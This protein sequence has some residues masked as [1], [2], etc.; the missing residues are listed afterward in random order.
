MPTQEALQATRESLERM[1]QFDV[2]TLAR[3]ED[4]GKALSFENALPAAEKLVQLY[5]RLGLSVLEDLTDQHLGTVKTQADADYSRFK[6]ILDFSTSISNPQTTRDQY[7]A[8]LEAA[9]DPAF[10]ALWQYISYGVS[11]AIDT[12]RLENESRAMLQGISDK[13]TSITASL[14]ESK[15]SATTALAEIRRVA[16][17]QGVSQQA[18]HFNTEAELHKSLAASWRKTTVNAAWLVGGYTALSLFFNQ[19]PWLKPTDAF[20]TVQLVSS[21]LLLFGVLAYLLALAAK[22]F[23]AHQ[24]NEIV[25]RHRQN[26]LM[27]FNALAQAAHNADNKDI[28][29]T[30]ASAC[31]FAPQD[32]GYTKASGGENAVSAKSVVELLPKALGKADG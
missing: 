12:Q 16:A 10:N 32:T 25:N 14:E 29:L 3:A 31:I 24:H 27:T 9:Y 5:Q 26:A 21:K 20:E 11:K 1:Q 17:E 4:L 22:N 13:A 18:I 6:N 2:K 28:V 30:H 8:Q 7:V 15:N 19:I 23:L